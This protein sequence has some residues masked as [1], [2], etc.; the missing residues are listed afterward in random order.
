MRIYFLLVAISAG[1]LCAQA[2]PQRISGFGLKDTT[3]VVNL[4]SPLS[5]KTGKAG[6]T[7]TAS[8]E[9]PSRYQG[10]VIEGRITK[11]K[12]PGKGVG[13][14]KAKVQFHF[15]TLTFNNQIAPVVANLV[16]VANSQGVKNID[17]EGGTI[18]VTSNRKR[19]LAALI[20]G[21][22][23]AGIGA[24]AGGAQGAA[25]GAAAGAGA[26]LMIGLTMTTTGSDVEFRPGSKFTL[27]ISD[28]GR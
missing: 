26:G 27:T 22:I 1:L 18:G 14:G 2:P 9:V 4:L 20:G 24:A 6:D 21:G 12:R 10:A 17:D 23:G 19:A 15:D 8:V 25:I 11:L 5:T 16:E 28:T 7:F 3:F 13:K